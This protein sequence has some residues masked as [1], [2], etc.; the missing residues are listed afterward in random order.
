MLRGEKFEPYIN[1]RWKFYE[2]LEEHQTKK[3]RMPRNT[4]RNR[5]R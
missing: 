4:R 3:T 1:D 2:K 5:Q